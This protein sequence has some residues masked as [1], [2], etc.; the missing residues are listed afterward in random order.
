[1]REPTV[2]DHLDQYLL[3]D[4]LARTAMATTFKG[5]DTEVGAPVCLKVPHLECESDIVFYR[6]FQREESIGRRLEHRNLVRTLEP[7]TKSRMYLVTEYV[8]GAALRS[9]IDA[10]PLPTAQ[11]LDIGCQLCEAVAYL[12]A[13]GI[14]HR[15]LKPENIIVTAEGV[16]KLLDF[17]IAL[18]RAARRLT[19]TR[20]STTMGTPDYLAPEQ[21]GGRR[22][23]ERCDVYAAGVILYEMLTGQ[24]PFSGD[25]ANAVMRAKTSE[26]PRPPT[27]FL[28][29][30]DPAL[31]AIISQAIARSARDRTRSA[32][33]LLDRLRRFGAPDG[34]DSQ[35]GPSPAGPRRPVLAR[36]IAALVLT[37]LT[38]LTWLSHHADS[39]A[40][41]DGATARSAFRAP[42]AK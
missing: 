1:M 14:A 19:W 24:L 29:Q 6:R 10:G 25:S 7:R 11:A 21:V 33:E 34:C 28:P 17:G 40:L 3:T 15:D 36:L 32:A 35:E 13:H 4:L 23:D 8:R 41:D 9:L 37:T 18:D 27:Y 12:H 31:S 22:G 2:G 20:L 16:V 39:R 26:E 5:H 42:P 38:S 30:L